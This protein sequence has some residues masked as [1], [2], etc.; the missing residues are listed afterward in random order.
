MHKTVCGKWKGIE[1]KDILCERCHKS[2]FIIVEQELLGT[3]P[4]QVQMNVY[5][6]SL[7]SK[8][9][10]LIGLHA[11]KKYWVYPLVSSARLGVP[12]YT[13]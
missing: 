5:I 7:R 8:H 4:T 13:Q 2:T 10:C 1:R 3:A 12:Q 6:Q 9:R 11:N